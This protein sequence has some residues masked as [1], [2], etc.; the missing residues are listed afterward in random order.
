MI[1]ACNDVGE[2]DTTKLGSITSTQPGAK[3]KNNFFLWVTGITFVGRTFYHL[4]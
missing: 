4:L 2:N 1:M 3:I